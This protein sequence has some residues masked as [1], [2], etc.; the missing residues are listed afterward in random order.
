MDHQSIAQTLGSYGEF[1]GAI[2]VVATLFYF[3]RQIRSMQSSHYSEAIV[4]T[5][6]G[7]I[8]LDQMYVDNAELIVKGNA[9]EQLSDADE[10]KLRHIYHAIQTVHFHY[11]IRERER[12]HPYDV[13][14]Q[15]FAAH[16]LKNPVLLGIFQSVEVAWDADSLPARFYAS[17]KSYLKD[18]VRAESL[19]KSL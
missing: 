4:S 1:I 16:L 5:V 6:D 17:V 7:E 15:V 19:R 10:L 18:P 8:A 12:G 11:Y 13:R 2:A 14:A 9:G 3:S